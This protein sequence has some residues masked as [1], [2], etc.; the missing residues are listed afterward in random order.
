ME[1]A[2]IS[3]AEWVRL[4]EVIAHLWVLSGLLIGAGL[5]YILAHGFIAS[6]ALTGDVD[7]GA[8]RRV[9]MP[10]YA[11]ALLTFVAAVAVGVKGLVL[12]IEILPEIFPRMII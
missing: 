1:I 4:S 11:I 3:E 7:E 5:S 9:R 8:A 6:L 2:S 12:A 10:L